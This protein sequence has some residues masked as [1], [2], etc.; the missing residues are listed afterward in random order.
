M[1]NMNVIL[2]K[3]A[4]EN[5]AVYIRFQSGVPIIMLC[6]FHYMVLCSVHSNP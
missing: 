3:Q 6:G 5:G 1:F 4:S 2:V